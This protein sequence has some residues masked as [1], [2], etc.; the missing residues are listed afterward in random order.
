M[1]SLQG[2]FFPLK[3]NNFPILILRGLKH[4]LNYLITRDDLKGF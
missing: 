1:E 4:I 3:G 2:L